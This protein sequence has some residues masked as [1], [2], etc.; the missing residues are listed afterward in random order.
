SETG[1]SHKDQ[2]GGAR[3]KGVCHLSLCF[4][5]FIDLRVR[6]SCWL[7]LPALFIARRSAIQ[8]IE[9]EVLCSISRAIDTLRLSEPLGRLRSFS[10]S[11]CFASPSMTNLSAS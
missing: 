8:R 7:T 1:A 3:E 2:R 9:T 10:P 5:G 6:Y 4:P 11:P